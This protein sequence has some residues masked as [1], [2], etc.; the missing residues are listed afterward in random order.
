MQILNSSIKRL[1]HGGVVLAIAMVLGIYGCSTDQQARMTKPASLS[2]G[3][4]TITEI[5]TAETDGKTLVHIAGNGLLTYTAVKQ[6]FPPAIIL[7]FPGTQLKD[8]A[9]TISVENSQ[10]KDIASSEIKGKSTTAR[11]EISL[12]RDLDYDVT[13]E[14][15]GIQVSIQKPAVV[16]KA[17][18][19]AAPPAETTK[20]ATVAPMVKEKSTP[21]ESVKPATA[22]VE[23]TSTP[24]TSKPAA[25]PATRLSDVR[26]HSGK[27]ITTVSIEANGTISKFDAFTIRNPAR[28]VVDIF[29]VS[30]PFKGSQVIPVNTDRLLRVRHFMGPKKLR[31]VMDTTEAYLKRFNVV[32]T[33]DGLNIQ[34]GAEH[35]AM[36]AAAESEETKQP[37]TSAA[38]VVTTVQPVEA[39][40]PVAGVSAKKPAWVNRIDFSSEAKGK[41]TV[42]VGTTRPV[43]YRMMRDGEKK[44]LLNLYDTN[45]PG[46][47]QRPLITTR[48]ESALDRISPIQTK[49]MGHRTVIA[50]EL[51]QSV[52]Y[53][54][55]QV[56]NLIL[57][58]FDAST[59]PPK[60]LDKANLPD[61]EKMIE[62]TEAKTET[63]PPAEGKTAEAGAT[64]EQTST[65]AAATT[66]AASAGTETA[67]PYVSKKKFTGEKIAL[68]FYKTDIRNVFRILQEVSGKNYAIDKDVSGTVTLSLEKPV[69]WDQVLDLVL[70][71]N[72][73]G[74]VQEGDI[75]RIA[76]LRT[77]TAEEKLRQA[78]LD[79]AK[80]A[81]EKEQNL[82]PLETEFIPINYADAQRDILPQLQNVISSRGKLSVSTAT[83]QIIIK[84]TAERIAAAKAL[85]KKLDRVTNQVL[86]EAR[87][88]EATTSFTRELGAEFGMSGSGF[89]DA[90]NGTMNYS[91]ATSFPKSTDSLLTWDFTK[92]M[93]TPISLNAKLTA[94]ETEGE[95]KTISAPRILTLDN[96]AATIKQG[97][98]YP[99]LQLDANGNTTVTF[100]DIALELTV[101]PHVTL[102]HRISMKINIT[103]NDLGPIVGSN[104]SFTVNEANTELLVDD[105]DTVVIGGV[106]KTTQTT[107]V[108]GVPGIKDI[109]V[110]G[111]LFQSHSKDKSR[112]ELLI[113][114]TPHIVDLN[115]PPVTLKNQS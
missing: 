101:T 75:V 59:V 33:D 94:L 112:N 19:S 5:R 79:A 70:R 43:T 12:T 30:S 47:R 88:V 41:S 68:D 2:E 1:I 86:I 16:A 96:K 54:I 49:K 72:Q 63:A 32:P 14:S 77:L 87:V 53:T 111:W 78:A 109:P 29:G 27:N 115:P 69:P 52:P 10:V 60:P 23:N 93:G 3:G 66:T 89:S 6:P 64:A 67:Q 114:I 58:H 18:S 28:I 81:N 25:P 46:Y 45:L 62:Q 71:M 50:F 35:H 105:G 104:Y 21:E 36:A 95:S 55:E 57:V 107:G 48:F 100:K 15:G 92:T 80:S 110:L 22:N 39:S 108:S 37:A 11:I 65:K 20:P 8:V 74:M 7:Y 106:N 82:E 73:L 9:P 76:T 98:S 56:Q 91:V 31:V 84:D 90:L 4:K 13:K 24:V 103:K 34:I 113:F 44:L 61:W 40:T 83:N 85:V 42:I 51:R 99:I 97:V 26:V 17:E 38:P 102:D